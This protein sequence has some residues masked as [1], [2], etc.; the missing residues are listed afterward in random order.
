[1][2]VCLYVQTVCGGGGDC[3]RLK[4]TV[5]KLKLICRGFDT[6][7]LLEE[8]R[9]GWRNFDLV[10]TERDGGNKNLNPSEK[11]VSSQFTRNQLRT[12]A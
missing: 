8:V 6:D 2:H 10:T 3:C 9:W 11:T 12:F 4:L 7:F 5:G 1:M